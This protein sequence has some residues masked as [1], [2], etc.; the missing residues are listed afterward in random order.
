MI[1]SVSYTTLST[2]Y[3]L[4]FVYNNLSCL[5]RYRNYIQFAHTYNNDINF[6]A[7]MK[8]HKFGARYLIQPIRSL[9][10]FLSSFLLTPKVCHL[11]LQTINRNTSFNFNTKK[12]DFFHLPKHC[13]FN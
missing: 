6:C 11:E 8:I 7:H 1:L 3:S 10:P 2:I 9:T 5:C 12:I 13:E 4:I